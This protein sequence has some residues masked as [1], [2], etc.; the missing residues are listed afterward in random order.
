MFRVDLPE[1]HETGEKSICQQLAE[2]IIDT[3]AIMQE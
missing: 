1:P 3:F 2:D